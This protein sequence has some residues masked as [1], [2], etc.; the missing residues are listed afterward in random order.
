M[1]TTEIYPKISA[2][3]DKNVFLARLATLPHETYT[4][5]AKEINVYGQGRFSRFRHRTPI[6][7]TDLSIISVVTSLS[8][9]VIM[10]ENT[11]LLLAYLESPKGA[12][13]KS[14]G[15]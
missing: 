10:D 3:E 13:F 8:I 5:I 12:Q 4:M 15:R 2:K 7:H 11:N 6:T 14:T 1:N 9:E